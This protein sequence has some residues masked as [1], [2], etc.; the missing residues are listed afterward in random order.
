MYAWLITGLVT[1]ELLAKW[2][3]D[4]NV[5]AFKD[6]MKKTIGLF[7]K[8]LQEKFSQGNQT[9][10]D[11]VAWRKLTWQNLQKK[12]AGADDAVKICVYWTC[13]KMAAGDSDNIK[14]NK[15]IFIFSV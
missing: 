12:A 7:K 4:G 5:K 2:H 3:F 11:L 15:Y 9:N 6:S 1:P 14:V 8:L 13:T 10:P